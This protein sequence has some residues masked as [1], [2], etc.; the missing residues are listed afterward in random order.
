VPSN[1]IIYYFLSLLISGVFHEF[2]HAIAGTCER[3]KVSGFGIFILFLYPG[4]FAEFKEEFSGLLP[5]QQLKIFCA[6]SWHNIT[7]SAFSYIC[8]FMLPIILFPCYQAAGGV[9]ITHVE[10]GSVLDGSLGP[11]QIVTSLGDCVVNNRKEWRSCF[12]Y[13]LSDEYNKK[14]YCVSDNVA[15]LDSELC[16]HGTNINSS[17]YCF[18]ITSS[19]Q[20]SKICAIAKD[21]VKQG[22]F[23]IINDDNCKGQWLQ[24]VLSSGESLIKI[25]LQNNSFL[26]FVGPP[27]ALWFSIPSV[28]DFL[29]RISLFD[30][31]WPIFLEKFFSYVLSISSALG[32]LNLAPVFYLDGAYATTTLLQLFAPSIPNQKRI[33][34]CNIIFYCTSFLL[35]ANV[36]LSFFSI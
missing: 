18:E 9:V 33:K 24:P 19:S 29:P 7:L 13:L 35:I 23:G 21:V 5:I 25:V 6:G 34:I 31:R 15:I 36:I 32:I 2:G 30:V 8:I 14:G 16:C 11:L 3:I 12:D 4:A 20:P 26:L 28:G 17:L 22:I 1:E 10:E 27:A